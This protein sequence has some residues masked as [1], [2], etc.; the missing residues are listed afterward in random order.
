[1]KGSLRASNRACQ[2]EAE[3]PCGERK[4]KYLGV[5]HHGVHQTPGQKEWRNDREPEK[6]A[7]VFQ[8][9]GIWKD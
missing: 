2:V 7:H 3:F 4:E 5:S 8:H 6:E 9:L 1:M